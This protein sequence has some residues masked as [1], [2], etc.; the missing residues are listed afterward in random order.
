MGKFDGMDP[1]LVRDLLTEVKHA[2][3]QMRAAEDRVR[4]AMQRA[5]LS[6]VTTHRPAQ[7]ADSV[8][9]MVKD[10][11]VR[12]GV[13][14]KRVDQ[15]RG[16][17]PGTGAGSTQDD[18]PKDVRGDQGKYDNPR[19]D[20]TPPKNDDTKTGEEAKTGDGAKTDA[21]GKTGDGA[22]TDAEG[23]TGDGAKTDA[24]GKNGKTGD[25]AK[26]DADGKTGDGA[27][28]DA[29]GKTGDGAKADADG[30][31]DSDGDGKTCDGAKDT[32]TG[33]KTGDQPVDQ[34]VDQP[35]DDDLDSRRDRGA[36]ADGGT[37]GTPANDQQDVSKPQIVEVDGVKVL[38]I[39]IDPP[40]AEQLE[41]LLQ[42]ADK[43]QA[44]EMPKLPADGA[45][46]HAADVNA[47][48][49]DGSDVVSADTTPP[50]LDALK[51]V[52]GHH[53]EIPPLDMP[54]LSET[55][56]YDTTPTDGTA[57]TAGT[58]DDACAS[59]T[60]PGGA[61]TTPGGT[62]TTP[63]RADTTPGGTDTT[64]GGT[65]TTPGRADTTPGGTGVTPDRP[66]GDGVGQGAGDGQGTGVRGAGD[67]GAGGTGDQRAGGQGAPVTIP[68]TNPSIQVQIAYGPET[69]A[70]NV[71]TW[72]SDG[73]DVV[74]VDVA[75]PSLDALRTVVE[76]HRD[77]QPLDMP[78]VEVPPGEYGKGEWAPRHIQPDGPQGEIDPGTPER[79]A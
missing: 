79:S 40:T 1:K 60:T 24:D 68:P 72:A 59:G 51:T 35:K 50:N 52:V 67:Q 61:D 47:W 10:V 16:D 73:S 49:N 26:T 33:D 20:E 71:N 53:R 78:S 57:P 41:D 3:T 17:V 31:T 11:N 36:E 14:E 76:H 12:L 54:G 43:V 39:P 70:S 46:T 18:E 15:P 64:P 6:A 58:N 23:K 42:N 27:K 2:A 65:D 75:P 29:D 13:L 77:I 7:V 38:Q 28:T 34:P 21:E 62:D 66:S 30:K 5:E 32:G 48:A 55:S 44:A 69:A 25:G 19:A 74:S 37:T 22:K 45:T 63:G 8:D 56:G 9:A 4:L